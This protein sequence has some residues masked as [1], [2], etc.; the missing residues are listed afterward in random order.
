VM[1]YT[2]TAER[3]AGPVWVFQC[4]EHPGA[5]SE[6]RRL[7]DVFRL[8]PEAIAYVA[9]V[10]EEAVE[11]ELVPVLPKS[12][13]DLVQRARAAVE[14]LSRHQLEAGQLSRKAASQLVHS[15]G[16]T[17]ADAAAILR[18]SPQRVSQLIADA[19]RVQDPPG[20]PAKPGEK[21]GLDAPQFDRV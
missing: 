7:G 21:V 6:S 15:C 5:I 1:R 17:G 16:L 13:S 3:G 12:I 19:R 11:I 2:V 20:L 9:D 8:M 4:R 10:D 14:M 18:V